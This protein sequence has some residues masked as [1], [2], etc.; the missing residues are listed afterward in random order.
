MYCSNA[1]YSYDP[2]LWRGTQQYLTNGMYL[3]FSAMNEYIDSHKGK[4]SE[5]SET[6]NDTFIKVQGV[7]DGVFSYDRV[8]EL[9]LAYYAGG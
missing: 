8:T 9:I 2:E 5:V 7:E 3:D 1:L 4:V 6:V